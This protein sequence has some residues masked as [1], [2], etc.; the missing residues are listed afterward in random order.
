MICLLKMLGSSILGGLLVALAIGIGE[1]LSYG[2][3]TSFGILIVCFFS[4]NIAYITCKVLG[5]D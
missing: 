5:V 2:V 4:M 3:K 1:I